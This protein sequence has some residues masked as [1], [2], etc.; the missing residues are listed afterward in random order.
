MQNKPLI[1]VLG[2]ALALSLPGCGKSRENAA[3]EKERLLLEEQAQRD[4]QK[5]NQA[6]NEVSKKLGRKAPS[7][8]IGVPIEPKKSEPKKQGKESQKQP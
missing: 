4:I 6:V 3:R 5:S 7:L 1:V 8:D 2:V